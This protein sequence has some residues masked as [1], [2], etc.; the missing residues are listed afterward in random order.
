[1]QNDETN[2]NGLDPD[3]REERA[4]QP[5]TTASEGAFCD[6]CG[7]RLTGRKARFCSDRCRMRMR[8]TIEE[9]R[10]RDLMNELHRAVRAVEVELLRE[11]GS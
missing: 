8:R 3:V 1:M 6:Q 9:E 4:L 7:R 10:R 2:Q 5:R 11:V